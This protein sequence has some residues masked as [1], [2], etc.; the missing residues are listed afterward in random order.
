M[1]TASVSD[2]VSLQSD[3]EQWVVKSKALFNTSL[4]RL[5]SNN[6][7]TALGDR[8]NG[9]AVAGYEEAYEDTLQFVPEVKCVGYTSSTFQRATTTLA[10]LIASLSCLYQFSF[11]FLAWKPNAF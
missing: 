1:A 9:N 7:T 11:G 3:K 5:Q 10:L 8:P 6:L 4:A 2:F